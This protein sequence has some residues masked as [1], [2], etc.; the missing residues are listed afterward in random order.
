MKQQKSFCCIGGSHLL[1]S[2]DIS[3]YFCRTVTLS[4]SEIE[5]MGMSLLRPLVATAQDDITECPSQLWP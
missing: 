4:T 5:L 3:K 1:N 2:F